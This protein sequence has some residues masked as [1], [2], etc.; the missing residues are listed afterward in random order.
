MN[1]AP[2]SEESKQTETPS[3][4][5]CNYPKALSLFIMQ[6]ELSSISYRSDYQFSPKRQAKHHRYDIQKVLI[7]LGDTTFFPLSSAQMYS[8]SDVTVQ[9]TAQITEVLTFN[10]KEENR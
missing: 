10:F 6:A 2:A 9:K 5:P 8:T 7:I 4:K 1:L 3:P